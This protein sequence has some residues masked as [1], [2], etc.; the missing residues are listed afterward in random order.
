M[1][2]EHQGDHGLDHRDR[3]GNRA[4]IVP[5]ARLDGGRTAL[6]VDGLLLPEDGSDRL[7]GGSNQ[8]GHAVADA[9]LDPAGVVRT[10]RNFTIFVEE[11]IIVS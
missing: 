2:A 6:A 11:W 10:G 1:I 3:S 5:A 9:T 4:G 7:E 8:D